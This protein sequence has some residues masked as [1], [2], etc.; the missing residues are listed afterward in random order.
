MLH[1]EFL[2]RAHSKRLGELDASNWKDLEAGRNISRV[3]PT[4]RD[5]VS[6]LNE[7]GYKTFSSCSGGHQANLRRRFDRHESGYIAFSPPSRIPFILYLALREKNQDFMFEAEAVIHDGNGD[8]R[9]T[10]YTQLDWQLLDE[11]KPKLR[12]YEN[13]FSEIQYAIDRLPGKQD[14]HKE[15]LTGL[16][17]KPRL[18]VGS[19]IVS[20]QMKRF[21]R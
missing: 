9:E 4:I 11:R 21:T 18:P 3:D 19:R 10:I 8:R 20:G 6:S 16:L 7:K 12:Y 2:R 1:N 15:V 13:L 17:G 5:I 14:G